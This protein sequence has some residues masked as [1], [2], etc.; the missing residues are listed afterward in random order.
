MYELLTT[1]A[2]EMQDLESRDP[3]IWTHLLAYLE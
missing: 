2:V 1:Q 3:D